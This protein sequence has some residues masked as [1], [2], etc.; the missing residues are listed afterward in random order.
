MEKSKQQA[1][2]CLH[3]EPA[4]CM[5]SCPFHFDVRDW[6]GRIQRGRFDAAFRIFRDAVGFPGV[7]VQLCD[8]RCAQ[9]CPRQQTDAPVQLRELER[10]CMTLAR[11]TQPSRFNVP[12]KAGRVHIVGGGISGLAC[13]LRMATRKYEVH[14][15]EQTNRIGGHLLHHMPEE[16]LHQ[17][18]D[19]QFQYETWHL[20]LNTRI[21]DLS[22]FTGDAVYVATGHGG[23]DFGLL[24]DRKATIV[25]TE[26]PG[27]FL[28]GSLTGADAMEAIA[29]GLHVANALEGYLKVGRMEAPNP[30]TCE[31][32]LQIDAC[33]LSPTTPVSAQKGMV[34]TAQ[35]AKDEAAR[36]LQCNCEV[37]QNRCD[38]MAY[39]K[40]YPKR[41][42]EEVEGTIHPAAIF[43]NRMA[44]RLIASCN[45]CGICK[46]ACP[47]HIDMQTLL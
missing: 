24:E 8:Q 39:Y 44:T 16:M 20:H 34:Y 27:V 17:E 31:T 26:Q 37:C 4:F 46:E 9:R 25:A 6:I 32:G 38:L 23:A 36:C 18:I 33:A 41:I 19:R 13:A 22:P 28:G 11:N 47:Q 3:D 7:V 40:K 15:Y 21:D 1:Q 10:A 14:V 35:Q 5:S 42:C 29:H 45:Q 2:T 30:K 12:A 43:A